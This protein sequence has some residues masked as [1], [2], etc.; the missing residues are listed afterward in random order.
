MQNQ[1][2]FKKILINSFDKELSNTANK[3][4]K[5]SSRVNEGSKAE[6]YYNKANLLLGNIHKISKGMDEI[7]LE[8]FN[9]SQKLKLH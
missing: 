7:I 2:T 5:L 1:I 4:N 8:N 6:K 3:L 9:N